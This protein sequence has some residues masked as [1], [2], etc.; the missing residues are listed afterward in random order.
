MTTPAAP[1]TFND[2]SGELMKLKFQKMGIALLALALSG[3]A[4]APS[5]PPATP[6]TPAEIAA[7]KSAA[8]DPRVFFMNV[9]F[10]ERNNAVFTDANRVYQDI[11][12]Y[13]PF[14]S[15]PG[16]ALPLIAGT[17]RTGAA[18][19]ALT[20]T[21]TAEGW[22]ALDR[23]A[24]L[25][26]EI[27]GPEPQAVQPRHVLDDIPGFAGV[28]PELRFSE[29]RVEM[30]LLYGRAARGN[31]WPLTRDPRTGTADIVL[32]MDLLRAFA[33]VQWD[34][35]NRLL[36]LST[37]PL[38]PDPETRR[39]AELPLLSVSGPLTVEASLEGRPLPVQLDVAGD[40]EFSMDQ[41]PSEVVR[42]ISLGDLVFRRVVA[43]DPR[44]L[45][46]SP[47]T[48]RL[49]LRA[50]SPYRLTLDNRRRM[51]YIEVPAPAADLDA[52]APDDLP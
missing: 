31:L 33:W 49:G 24:A 8:R 15:P 19:R 17:A 32:G 9:F 21:T 7:L 36:V 50:L 40:Y 27:L 12:V 38:A 16:T 25:G 51:V 41:P 47:G 14:V 37:Q 5:F 48:A 20:D 4:T 30:A 46:L 44:T 45:G 52:E 13:L 3:C 23:R 29:L 22:I 18:L 10:D 43:R 42:Q 11:T 2:A 1:A 26:F 6:Y 28:L 34:F 35:P 39:M